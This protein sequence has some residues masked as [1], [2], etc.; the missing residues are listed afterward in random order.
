MYIKIETE[1]K[2]GVRKMKKTFKVADLVEIVNGR[3]KFFG[4]DKGTRRGA[5]SLLESVLHSTDNYAGFRYLCSNE[6][7]E[8]VEPGIIYGKNDEGNVFPDQSRV[9]YYIK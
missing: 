7:P 6:L 3:N 9:H 2:T 4:G 1:T 5:N 8:G